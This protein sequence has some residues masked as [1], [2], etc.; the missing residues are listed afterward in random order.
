V[1]VSQ[2]VCVHLLT[3]DAVTDL[4]GSRIYHV[5]VPQSPAVFPVIRVQRISQQEDMHLRGSEG[6]KSARVQVD[7]IAMEG[8]GINAY[9]VA[10]AVDA[11][12][13]GPGDGTGLCG[14][15]GAVGSPGFFIHSIVP[16][17]VNET[18]DAQELKQFKIMRD[19]MV[20]FSGD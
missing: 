1:T 7:S 10:A 18:Y 16:A 2:A 13:H 20:T 15:A 5:K 12:V 4:V 14:F 8:S 19:Y 9:A 17:G 3:L 6:M 11:A